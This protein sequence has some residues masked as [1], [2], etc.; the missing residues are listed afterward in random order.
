MKD[1]EINK[2][3]TNGIE[4]FDGEEMK[5]EEDLSEKIEKHRRHFVDWD[6]CLND[7][8]KDIKE[9]IDKLIDIIN[10][11]QNIDEDFKDMLVQDIIELFGDK[12]I[13]EG[14]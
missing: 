8:T 7:I 12:L 13:N 4:E 5:D 14:K 9:T 10:N 11:C 1:K 2:I 6:S 3:M